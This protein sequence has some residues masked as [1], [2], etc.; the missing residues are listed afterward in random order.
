MWERRFI[1]RIDQARKRELDKLLFFSLLKF[2]DITIMVMVPGISMFVGFV[3]SWTGQD[4]T[5]DNV[6]EDILCVCH[7]EHTLGVL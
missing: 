1:E 5:G 4:R 7:C 2:L 3:L 6:G